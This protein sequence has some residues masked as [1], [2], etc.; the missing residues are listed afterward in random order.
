M[1]ITEQT[2]QVQD[3]WKLNYNY[4][5]SLFLLKIAGISFDLHI[6]KENLSD[7]SP[8]TLFV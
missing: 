8:A 3:R 4:T 7:T 1:V 2:K 6:F 5:F